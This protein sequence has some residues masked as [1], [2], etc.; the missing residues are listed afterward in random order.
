MS[1]SHTYFADRGTVSSCIDFLLSSEFPNPLEFRTTP[2][3][4]SD[5]VLLLCK[6]DVN[7]G[8]RFGAGLRKLNCTILNDEE[9]CKKLEAYFETLVVRK[10]DYANI[11]V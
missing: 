11:L 5:H 4:F 1:P 9:V 7:L 10:R 6:V 2:V 3:L 8:V